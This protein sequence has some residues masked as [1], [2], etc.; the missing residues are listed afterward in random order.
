MTRSGVTVIG[1]D[2]LRLTLARASSDLA[3]LDTAADRTARLVTQR[4]RDRAPKRSGRLAASV[5]ATTDGSDAAVGSNLVYAPVIHNGWAAH[6]IA[7]N[8]FLV[9]VAQD[10]TPIWLSYYR[11]DLSR[12][13]SQVRGA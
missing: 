1:D 9:P 3:H 13:I 4:A 5:T 8:P 6:G 7:A 10:S 11:A 12:A 2:M